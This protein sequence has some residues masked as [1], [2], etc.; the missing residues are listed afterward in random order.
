MSM[1]NLIPT[2][3]EL[4]LGGCEGT[5]DGCDGCLDCDGE[6]KKA[7]LEQKRLSNYSLHF[8]ERI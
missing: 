8:K 7:G 2:T 5:C 1:F 6:E 4:E 3:T